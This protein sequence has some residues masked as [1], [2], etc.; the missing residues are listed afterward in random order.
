MSESFGC[1]AVF[2]TGA[3]DTGSSQCNILIEYFVWGLNKKGFD[4][5]LV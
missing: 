3:P 4:D 5:N 1:K 2:V